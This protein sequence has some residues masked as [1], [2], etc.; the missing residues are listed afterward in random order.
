MTKEEFRKPSEIEIAVMRRLLSAD[1]PGKTEVEK[2]LE[3][4][5]VRVMDQEGSLELRPSYSVPAPVAK[6][7]PVEAEGIDKDK[8]RVHFLLHV[9]DGFVNELEIYKDDGSAIKCMPTP[10]SLRVIVLPG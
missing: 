6:R 10:S 2:Q 1:F 5:R 3:D 8:I 7:I 4:S 9:V